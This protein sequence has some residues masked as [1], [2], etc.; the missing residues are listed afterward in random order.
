[1]DDR[2]RTVPNEKRIILQADSRH[3]L[4]TWRVLLPLAIIIAG[5][6]A[7][8]TSFAG[9]FI[10]DDRLH[11]LGDR[12]LKA[13]WPLWEALGRRR[14]IVDYSLAVNHAI[15]GENVWGFHATNLAVHILAGLTL[16]GVV[17]R[18]LSREPLRRRFGESAWWLAMVIALIWVVHPLQTQSITYL[19][20]RAESLMGLF[21][22]LTLYC[23]IRG[24]GSPRGG[25]WYA[26]AIISSA[27]GM[28]SKAVMVT[29]PVAVLLYDRV[30]LSETWKEIVRRRWALYLALV[31]TWGVLYFSGVAMGVL[32]A[33]RPGS[34]V[35]FSYRGITPVNYALTQC[36]VLLHYIEL[37]LVPYSLCLDYGW[38]TARTVGQFLPQTVVVVALLAGTLWALIKRPPLG[39]AAAW[40]FIILAPTSSIVPIKDPIFEHRMYL[41]LASIVVLVV[42]GVDVALR[43]FATR[44]QYGFVFRRTVSTGLTVLVAGALTYGTI[45][46]NRTYHSEALMWRD[47]LTKRPRNARAAE[48][49]G[50]SLL[51]EGKLSE[52][53]TTLQE[54]VKISP[55]SANVRNA[56][57][58][59]LV[60]HGRLDEAIESFREALRLKPLYPRALVNMGNAMND[61]GQPEEA[62]AF[63]AQAVQIRPNDTDARLNLGNSYLGRGD[64]DEAIAQYS[65][66][67]QFDPIHAKGWGN[68]GYALLNKAQV[69]AGSGDAPSSVALFDPA[70]RALRRALDINPESHNAWNNLGLALVMQSAA[71]RENGSPEEAEKKLDD[72]IGALRQALWFRADFAG[73]HYN[74]ANVLDEK[75]DEVGAVRHYRETLKIEPRH[76]NARYQLGLLMLRNGELDS[77]RQTFEQVLQLDPGHRGAQGALQ[78]MHRQESGDPTDGS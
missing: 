7:Y 39:Y 5:V 71:A 56:L 42:I 62:L 6:V 63:F 27:L 48:N 73:A 53:L 55:R 41:A 23:V 21:Y 69:E 68:L 30:F 74:L 64:V 3:P 37:S 36:G 70:T 11:I 15:S 46:R 24:A 34:H 49:L 18:T 57:G 4:L 12:R 2:Q 47:V 26:A 50:V 59:A 22:L 19:I 67:V 75:G 14:P 1:M 9:T 51:A 10:F 76:I 45:E 54:A 29:A 16:F 43:W 8:W 32:D 20:Q 78:E 17:R 58:F 52:A 28:G 38:P 44:L 35:G 25:W 60:A 77:A 66:I 31:A 72:A 33:T 13:L 40:F 61:K 65:W